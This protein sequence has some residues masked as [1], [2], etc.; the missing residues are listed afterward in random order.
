MI[1]ILAPIV[2]IGI[3]CFMLYV[4]WKSYVS[5]RNIGE[6]ELTQGV[7]TKSSIKRVEAAFLPDIE[8]Q[9]AVLGVEYKGISVTLPPDV[10]YDPQVAQG[11][12]EEYPVGKKV[13]V[14][15]NPEFHHVAVL[16]KEAGAGAWWIVVMTGVTAFFFL[17]LG[18]AYL[19]P[20]FK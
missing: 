16:E 2:S 18:F 8:Y 13:D 7:I 11:L 20:L 6:W 9:Y 17:V 10:V 12:L 19:L 4:G 15:Y 5:S 3:G 14:F 1:A